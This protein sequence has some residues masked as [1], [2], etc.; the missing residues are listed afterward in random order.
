LRSIELTPENLEEY[1]SNINCINGQSI[2]LNEHELPERIV[3]IG[4]IHGDLEALFSILLHSN[5]IDISGKWIAYNTFLVQ[6]GD[7]FDKGRLKPPL[8]S[9]GRIPLINRIFPYDIIDKNGNIQT[10]DAS[11]GDHNFDFGEVGDELVI[12]KFLTDL[13]IQA[14]AS[15]NKFGN[16][17][18]LL[19]TGNHE[20]MNTSQFDYFSDTPIEEVERILQ[21]GTYEEIQQEL[22][23]RRITEID[24]TPIEFLEGIPISDQRETLKQFI[25][26]NNILP[27][28]YPHPM[29]A[30]LFGGPRFPIRREIFKH[31]SGYLARKLACIL[32]V[33]VV[34]GDFIFSHGGISSINLDTINDITEL[35]KINNIFRDYLLGNPTNPNDIYKYFVN[36]KSSILWNRSLGKENIDKDNPND[37]MLCENI[38]EFVRDR[39]HRENLNMVV[40]HD[41]QGTCIDPRA[42]ADRSIP[43]VRNAWNRNNPDGTIDRCIVL[44]TVWCNNQIYRIDTGMSRMNN[45]PDYRNPNLGLLNSLLIELNPD[46]SKKSVSVM[47]GLLGIQQPIK[48]D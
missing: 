9:V 34:V 16:S 30:V 19:C 8:K 13:H 6:T 47:N 20:F 1:V 5:V 35:Q 10:L 21:E 22:T 41:I 27:A 14:T 18:V 31:G 25:G 38:L 29:D 28:Q 12:L 15:D 40:G 4:D 42:D 7:I 48:K 3:A 39:L 45:S 44:P 17:R 46:G 36:S 43:R 33:I 2:F 26:I 11:T 37:I 32:N 24:N 23:K